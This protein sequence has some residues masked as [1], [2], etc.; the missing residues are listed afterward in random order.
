MRLLLPALA[1][2]V[3]T[4]H[5][6]YA[7]TGV[8]ATIHLLANG[9]VVARV[10]AGLELGLNEIPA[11]APPLPETIKAIVGGKEAT[12]VYDNGSLYLVAD[13]A[14]PAVITY[15]VN[16]SSDD[17]GRLSFEVF[18][19]TVDLVIEPGVVLLTLPQ[20]LLDVRQVDD[21]VVF[22]IEG[23]DRIV[24]LPAAPAKK[25]AKVKTQATQTQTQA[26]TATAAT[27]RKTVTGTPATTTQ[28]GTSTAAATA[29]TTTTAT[30]TAATTATATATATSPSTT[31]SQPP[32]TTRRSTTTSTAPASPATSTSPAPARSPAAQQPPATSTAGAGGPPLAALAAVLLVLLAAVAAL[33]ARRRP[34]AV[35]GPGEAPELMTRGLDDVDKLILRKLEE[36]GGEMLQ[37]QL[38]R[39]TG[40]PKTT[41]WRHVRRL[42]EQGYIE[43][44]REGKANRLVLRRRPG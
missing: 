9:T 38:Q 39:E 41:L 14:A 1:L 36:H 42:A 37:S 17:R 27:P 11:P 20:R 25:P 4:A 30:A 18:N 15:L 23:P 16:V 13:K 7:A 2:M 44:I 22:R 33:A 43:I 35:R 19:T 8:N 12:V 28:R 32:A 31:T 34:G 24:F 10:E 6:A 26:S 21:K 29:A 3:F 5:H 40:L